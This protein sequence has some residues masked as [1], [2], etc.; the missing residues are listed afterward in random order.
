M[1]R[2]RSR[3]RRLAGV[4]PP[5][6]ALLRLPAIAVQENA[7]GALTNVSANAENT[8]T[9]AAAG[10]PASHR[11]A[12]FAVGRRRADM[13]YDC[14]G[15]ICALMSRTRSRSSRPVAF[16]PHRAAGVT[17]RNVLRALDTQP[18]CAAVDMHI[19]CL[20]PTRVRVIDSKL[21]CIDVSP[22]RCDDVGG[23]VQ[24]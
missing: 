17:C 21:K 9:I 19:V 7:A 22:K 20:L 24:I 18:W 16:P 10:H 13:C 12:R 14:A 11:A 5:L 4:I 2:T 3:S 15:S 8:V 23:R 6:I 1:P